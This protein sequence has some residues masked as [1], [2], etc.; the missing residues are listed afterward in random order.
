MS[1]L[2]TGAPSALPPGD[3]WAFFFSVMA[4]LDPAIH[5][6]MPD[7]AAGRRATLF[8]ATDRNL[9]SLT[10]RPQDVDGRVKP[11]HDDLGPVGR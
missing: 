5:V 6:S 3:A 4:G 7:A 2:L 1:H 9:L 10:A 8:A 11:G